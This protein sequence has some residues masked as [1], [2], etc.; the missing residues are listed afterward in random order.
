M[1]VRLDVMDV[2]TSD[3]RD[4]VRNVLDDAVRRHLLGGVV[5]EA[6]MGAVVRADAWHVV[7]E[8]AWPTRPSR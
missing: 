2:V 3:V 1:S 5:W 7:L 4:D 6:S 8:I